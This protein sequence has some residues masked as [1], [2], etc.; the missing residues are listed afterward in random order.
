MVII[1]NKT[2]LENPFKNY[3]LTTEMRISVTCGVEYSAD[4]EQVKA[5]TIKT[6]SKSFEQKK[7][8]KK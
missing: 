1:P 4:L 3:S 7:L 2:I 6:I 8:T 5:L